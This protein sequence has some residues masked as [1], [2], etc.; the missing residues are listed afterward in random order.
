MRS[1]YH[2]RA[3]AAKRLPVG[4]VPILVGRERSRARR[5]SQPTGKGWKTRR[6]HARVLFLDYRS[7]ELGYHIGLICATHS[8]DTRNFTVLRISG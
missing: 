6:I 4:L 7:T 8:A 1:Q 3:G 5:I 2:A